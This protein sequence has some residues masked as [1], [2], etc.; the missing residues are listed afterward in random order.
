M[1]IGFTNSIPGD[2]AQIG[3]RVID[4]GVAAA[5]AGACHE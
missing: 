4:P 2:T 1:A 3:D 5:S